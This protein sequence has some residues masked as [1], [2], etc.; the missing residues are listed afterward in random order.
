M[1]Q[2]MSRVKRCIDSEPMKGYWGILKS[3][4]YSLKKNLLSKKNLPKQSNNT[5]ISTIQTVISKGSIA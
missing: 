3:E 5:L 1:V 4:I 2:S